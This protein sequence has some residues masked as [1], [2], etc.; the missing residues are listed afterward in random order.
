MLGRLTQL[1][2]PKPENTVDNS[3]A[4]DFNNPDDDDKDDSGTLWEYYTKL[5]YSQ[6]P[7]IPALSLMRPILSGE[8]QDA[9]FPHQH[10]S[11]HLSIV[12]KLLTKM[13][14]INN[15][16]LSD[17]SLRP[18]CAQPLIDFVREDD[19]LSSLNIS[20]NPLIG[21]KAMITLLE[22][23]KDSTSLESLTISNTGCTKH[24]GSSIA[25]VIDGCHILIK[26]DISSCD[27]KQSA[28]EIAQT[29]PNN[30]KLKQLN[31]AK[32]GLYI[33][34]RRFALQLGANVGKCENLKKLDLSSN[35]ITS[36]QVTALMKGLAN[37]PKL[38]Y[39]NL[40]KNCIDETG[41]RPIAIFLG[42]T[43]SI[44]YLDLS[45]N[46]LLN[47]T[48]NKIRGQ[49]KLEEDA[50]KPGG[51]DKKKPSVYT[52]GCYWIINYLA[53]N[54]GLPQKPIKI[55]MIGIVVDAI[56]WE[57]K[58]DVLRNANPN[59]E[60]EY[61]A[62]ANTFFQFRRPQTGIPVAPPMSSRKSAASARSGRT[63]RK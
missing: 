39:L 57:G 56:E 53:K 17:N 55:R 38:S 36:E 45:Q 4:F 32:N 40:S 50:K 62:P 18:D 22:G 16:D 31:M 46:Q 34:G 3:V 37:A 48:V 61:K 59:V 41:G 29:L 43:T 15:L 49:K 7:P 1:T 63:P 13:K 54:A 42:K 11:T 28:L 19:Q 20:D 21:P 30:P 33:G 14:V 52:P 2:A 8:E 6:T 35:A 60:I 12:L 25:H 51:K 44:K 5:C 23:I 24:V 26:L 47:V 9:I 10:I 27:L 58:L